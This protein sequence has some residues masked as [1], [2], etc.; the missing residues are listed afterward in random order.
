MRSLTYV[1]GLVAAI[2]IGMCQGPRE[3]GI[4]TARQGGYPANCDNSGIDTGVACPALPGQTCAATHN[5]FNYTKPWD[6]KE[7]SRT[8]NACTATG[9]QMTYSAGSNRT[10]SCNQVN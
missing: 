4:A 3:T 8:L 6:Q 10:D 7:F 5:T 1:A 2:A 9:C